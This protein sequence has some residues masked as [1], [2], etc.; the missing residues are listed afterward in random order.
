MLQ[1][2]I[3]V[4]QHQMTV[5]GDN[6]QEVLKNASELQTIARRLDRNA[7]LSH[8]KNDG[9]DFYEASIPVRGKNGTRYAK[10]QLGNSE[11][12]LFLSANEPW[13]IYD[14]D[15]DTEYVKFDF[16]TDEAKEWGWDEDVTKSFKPAKVTKQGKL[17]A[18]KP[19]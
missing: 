16:L 3:Q 17:R 4:G 12:E 7:T 18:Y 13:R 11:G 8:R 15:T 19:A 9:F 2:Q 5:S 14:K 6:L 1:M 10:K